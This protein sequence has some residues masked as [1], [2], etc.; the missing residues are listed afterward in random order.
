M[1]EKSAKIKFC[2][3]IGSHLPTNT[4]YKPQLEATAYNKTVFFIT[5][6]NDTNSTVLKKS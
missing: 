1:L 2:F 3:H 6:V 5:N 4:K